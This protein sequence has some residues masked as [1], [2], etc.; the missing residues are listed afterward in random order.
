MLRLGGADV[1]L[2][3]LELLDNEIG[4]RGALGLGLSL[5]K[6]HNLSLLTLKLD[7]NPLIGSIGNNNI[8]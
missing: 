5:S 4:P 3:Y 8:V 2:S 6:G 1:K 7:F